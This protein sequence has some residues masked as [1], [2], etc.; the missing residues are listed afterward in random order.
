MVE[1]RATMPIAMRDIAIRDDRCRPAEA[2]FERWGRV[3]IEVKIVR[4]RTSYTAGLASTSQLD[5]KSDAKV[6]HR[7]GS[8]AICG[9]PAHQVAGL[10]VPVTLRS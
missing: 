7:E 6:N 8:P 3:G 2:A 10:A 1:I 5:D 9:E 4:N